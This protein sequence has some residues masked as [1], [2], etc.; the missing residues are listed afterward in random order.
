MVITGRRTQISQKFKIVKKA[1]AGAYIDTYAKAAV[2][3]LK[4]QGV[5]VVGSKWKKANVK[6]T[7]GGK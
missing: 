2:A 3:A 5:D 6:V 4:G 7:E 1:P